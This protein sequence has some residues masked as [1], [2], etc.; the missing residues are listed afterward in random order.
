MRVMG[1]MDS[2]EKFIQGKYGSLGRWGSQGRYG[3]HRCM[4]VMV[5]VLGSHGRN[6]RHGS[7]GIH[8]LI[9]GSRQRCNLGKTARPGEIT[10]MVGG[11]Q[12]ESGKSGS[13]FLPLTPHLALNVNTQQQ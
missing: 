10:V 3:S 13:G 9:H 2:R 12:P 7:H 5:D 4:V 8:A 11:K 1:G 6:G